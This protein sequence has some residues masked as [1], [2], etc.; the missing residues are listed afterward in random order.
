SG[1]APAT[2]PDGARKPRTTGTAP[3]GDTTPEATVKGSGSGARP[4]GRDR[5]GSAPA[6]V[7]TPERE[8]E[9]THSS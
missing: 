5:A 8:R 6:T 4:A 9:L 7:K 2:A 3:G 1:G